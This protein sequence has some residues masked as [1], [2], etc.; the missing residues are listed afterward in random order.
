MSSRREDDPPEPAVSPPGVHVVA[1]VRD[2]PPVHVERGADHGTNRRAEKTYPARRPDVH[3]GQEVSR[4]VWIEE[5]VRVCGPAGRV[6]SRRERHGGDGRARRSGQAPT[7]AGTLREAKHVAAARHGSR[8]ERVSER[9]VLE[10]RRI[11][12]GPLPDVVVATAPHELINR[13]RPALHRRVREHER[14]VDQDSVES[15]LV[16]IGVRPLPSGW[17]LSR[18]TRRRRRS[19]A[20]S[21]SICLRKWRTPY[22]SGSV[23][24]VGPCP[25]KRW[26]IACSSAS[27]PRGASQT[28]EYAS[29]FD[30]RTPTAITSADDRRLGASPRLEERRCA[31]DRGG[32]QRRRPRRHPL[33]IQPRRA[34][35]DMVESEEQQDAATACDEVEGHPPRSSAPGEQE[36]QPRPPGAERRSGRSSAKSCAEGCGSRS[37]ARFRRPGG[38]PAGVRGWRLPCSM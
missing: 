7:R 15:K 22:G 9:K 24:S 31:G 8:L 30:H 14:L 4:A 10:N 20:P 32:D 36:A 33:R 12:V 27:C 34:Q 6:A 23:I 17:P 18:G 3:G 16:E 26:P 38:R 35:A 37:P 28:L 1:Q 25:A 2:G 13:R 19:D 29:P 11:R 21:G 5:A